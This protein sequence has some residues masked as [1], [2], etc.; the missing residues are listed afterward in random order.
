VKLPNADKAIVDRTKIADYLLN[1]AHPDNGGKA[2]FFESLG[3]RSSEP[4]LLTEELRKLARQA[5]VTKATVSP[6][7]QKYVIVGQIESPTGRAAN[8]RT[9]WIVDEGRDVA[10]LVTAYPQ[11]P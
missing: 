6:H 4:E 8:V 1:A 7:G 3:F 5:E 10:R 11:K 2:A 9:I